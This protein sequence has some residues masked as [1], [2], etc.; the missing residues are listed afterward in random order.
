[1]K[2]EQNERITRIGPD[3]PC[4]ALM[5]HYWQ[6]VALVD[7]FDPRLDARMAQRPLKA[8]RVLGQDFILF[9][10]D[11]GRW[12]L[13]D[14]DCPHRNADLAFAR[15]EGDGVRCPFHGWKFDATGRC[16]ETPGEPVGSRLCERVQQGAYP[17]IE[18]SG[19]L[20]AWL[21]QADA[22]PPFPAFDCFAAPGTHTFAYKG[23]WQCNWLQAFEVGLDPVHTSFLHRFLNDAPLDAI[24]DNAAGKQFRSASAGDFGG[25]RW[26]MTRVMREFHRPDISFEPRPWGLQITTLRPMTDALTHVRITHGIFPSTFVIPLSETLTITQMHVPIDDTRTYWYAFFTS[27]DKPVD[28]EAM[29]LQRAQF[30]PGPDFIPQSGRHNDW[31]F[32]AQEQR[33]ATFLGMGEED[34]NVHD[35]W[36]VE[37]MGPIQDRTREHLGTTDKVIMANRRMLL[38]A[39]DTVAAGGTPPGVGDAALHAQMH[40]PDTVDG[41]APAGTWGTWWREQ[42]ETKRAQAPWTAA[43]SDT[44]K[45]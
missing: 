33:T 31:G 15:H 25:E 37:S 14:R 44:V 22:A 4:G 19:V 39:I 28:K 23:M 34:I 30:I 3:T 12:G 2:A 1:M 9:K 5:R 26:P 17:V 38:A 24:G 43:A 20:F 32:N 18:R 35:Q 13:L 10:D 7:E 40:G 45:A 6:P 8:V 41:I 36:A 27:F 21:G 42:T 16:L 11:Q 29:R